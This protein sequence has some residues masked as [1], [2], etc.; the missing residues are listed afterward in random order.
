MQLYIYLTYDLTR[1][2]LCAACVW[3]ITVSFYYLKLT[4]TCV[5][6]M[7]HENVLY[8]SGSVS[9]ARGSLFWKSKFWQ[10]ENHLGDY[11]PTYLRPGSRSFLGKL[12]VL[13]PVK[14]SPHFK[15]P[16]G[17]LPHS[18]QRVSCVSPHSG[19]S[20]PHNSTVF[21]FFL[22]IRLNNIF[23]SVPKSSQ[24]PVSLRFQPSS[25]AY[26]CL[27]TYISEA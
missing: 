23:P 24:F 6:I 3:K 17:S 5:L 14:K 1:S 11:L 16:K 9:C 7:N 20:S 10:T 4:K 18:Q 12:V 15:K 22:K 19:K 26:L 27:I 13:Q 25:Y 2:L 8:G 21:F